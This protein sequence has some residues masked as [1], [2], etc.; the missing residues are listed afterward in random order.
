MGNQFRPMLAVEAD[1]DKVIFP[2][3]A[4]YK[5]DGIRAVITPDGPRTRSLK[6][7]PNRHVMRLMSELPSGLDG[8]LV[9]LDDLGNVDFRATTSGIMSQDGEPNFKY[10]VFDDFSEPHKAFFERHV[11]LTIKTMGSLPHW[12]ECV[13]HYE[14]Y[15]ANDV[16]VMF[17]K[18]LAD[19]YEGLILRLATAPY[20]FNRST[21]KEQGM[22]KVKPW[23][24]DECEI[25]DWVRK[26]RNDNVATKN[27]LGR[28]ERSSK[29]DGLVELDEV[30]VLIGRNATWDRIEIGTGMTLAERQAWFANPPLGKTV[31]FRYI[32]VGGYDKPRHA[33]F[34]GFRHPDD[35]S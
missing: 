15:N 17:E 16:N 20:K 11:P 31:R 32:K 28:T 10:L 35:M 5:L 27:E 24:D 26:T 18:A 22:L 19:G 1:L 29:K 14:V 23:A 7:I 12:V 8:E 34:A 30:G 33:S 4:S 2:M 13:R 9:I 21:L 3:L 6:P 25:Y